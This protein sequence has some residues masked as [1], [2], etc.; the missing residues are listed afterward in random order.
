M[1][2]KLYWISISNAK[3]LSCT[4]GMY[5]LNQK[6][7][8]NTVGSRYPVPLG[9]VH[10]GGFYNGCTMKRCL[11]RKVDFKTNALNNAHVSQLLP[12]YIH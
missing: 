3:N 12:Y 7:T 8:K 9:L 11:H 2:N 5:I 1:L 10:N 6:I 4:V